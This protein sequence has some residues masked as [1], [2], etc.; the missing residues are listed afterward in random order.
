MRPTSNRDRDGAPTKAFAPSLFVWARAMNRPAEDRVIVDPGPRRSPSIR[1]RP[2]PA[3]STPPPTSARLTSTAGS[4]FRPSPT[5]SGSP[6]RSARSP[7]TATRRSTST[8][9][10][11]S[12]ASERTPKRP[13]SGSS[14]CLLA[15]GRNGP[16]RISGEPYYR[17]ADRARCYA[18]FF[19]ACPR[20]LLY[21]VKR[22]VDCFMRF[23]H[24]LLIRSGH[25]AKRLA[26]L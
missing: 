18:T 13:R 8:L 10:L 2:S 5:R 14:E 23:S 9:A 7:A 24:C 26:L 6:T 22:Q 4:R 21:G 19:A 15:L 20:L 1:A 25:K 17:V 3:T 16:A 11:P 12:A